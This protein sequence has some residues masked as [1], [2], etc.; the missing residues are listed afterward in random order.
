MEQ[1]RDKGVI[2]WLYSG[3]AMI[4]I[5]VVVGGIT[6]LTGSGLSMVEWKPV[7]GF[8]PPIGE[9]EWLDVFQKY[10]ATPE[11]QYKNSWMNLT[12][13]K[14]IFFWEY[15]HR[16]WGRLIGL[17]F[18]LP[19]L[20]FLAKGRLK[21]KLLKNCLIIFGLGGLQGFIGWFMVKSG[22]RDIPEVSHY[23][24]A[25]HLCTAFF[26]YCYILWVATNLLLGTEDSTSKSKFSKLKYSTANKVL[27]IL[28][29]IQ[30]IYG[31]FMSGL[32]AGFRFPTFPLME[33]KLYAPYM[34]DNESFFLNFIEN[35][36]MI[37]F[38]HRYLA[39]A[40]AVYG[41]YL[42]MKI[43]KNIS[44]LHVRNG[45]IALIAAIAM[46]FIFG[47]ITIMAF[48]KGEVPVFWGTVHQAGALVLLTAAVFLQNRLTNL[49]AS[50]NNG[51][52]S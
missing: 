51:T 33:G 38:I 28:V 10:K 42:A 8:L 47:V 11:W 25:L 24:L 5:M 52:R 49:E 15:F 16:V 41:I 2:L 22:L 1:K 12:D 34:F 35:K 39:M 13:F 6:R 40:V 29:L 18:L 26:L 14:G 17:V 9:A 32:K 21:G 48:S 23:R 3:C 45:S 20:F 4:F 44:D 31:A 30:I 37:Q 43:F 27:L 19:F 50:I 46:Q 7:M 36:D